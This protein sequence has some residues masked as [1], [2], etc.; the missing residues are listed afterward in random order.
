M[1][2]L[3]A[4]R[5]WITPIGDTPTPIWNRRPSLRLLQATALIIFG[6]V[7]ITLTIF[8]L[9]TVE[10]D[11]SN[12][13]LQILYI[14]NLLY[15]ATLVI[16]LFASIRRIF[17]RRRAYITGSNLHRR[18]GV[19][20]AI[21]AFIPTVMIAVFSNI[22]VNFSLDGWFSDRIS[23]VVSASLAAAQAYELQQRNDLEQDIQFIGFTLDN[24]K[25]TQPRYWTA[26]MFA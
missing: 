12:P 20:L 13:T 21:L 25:R 10:G 18:L 1:V 19:I 4:L 14:I 26:G 11:L 15:S 3:D 8:E 2:M 16:L 5:L 23:N 24:L 6:A 9:R 7:L 17:T 22:V